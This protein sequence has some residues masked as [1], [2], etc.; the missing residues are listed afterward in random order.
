M[1]KCPCC[2]GRAIGFGEW[3]AGLNAFRTICRSCG[4]PLKATKATFVAAI[5]T[6]VVVMGA[7]VLLALSSESSTER[8]ARMAIIPIV[9][10]VTLVAYRFCGY[11]RNE[12]TKQPPLDAGPRG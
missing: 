6:F 12:N 4:V 3:G 1:K 7:V 8:Y 2:N 5:T 11:E 10:G 9:L